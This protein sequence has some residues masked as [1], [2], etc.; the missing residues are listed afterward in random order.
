MNTEAMRPLNRNRQLE[1]EKQ[2][3]MID[4][5]DIVDDVIFVF[6]LLCT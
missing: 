3:Q 1:G 2:I 5:F 4:W 6:L